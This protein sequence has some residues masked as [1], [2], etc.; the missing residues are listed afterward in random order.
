M[1]IV[2]TLKKFGVIQEMND[3]YDHFI[4]GT[5]G[6]PKTDEKI[7]EYVNDLIL[8]AYRGNV[9]ETNKCKLAPWIIKQ[10]SDIGYEN[11]TGD[12]NIKF[13]KILKWFI[14]SNEDDYSKIENSNIEQALEIIKKEESEKTSSVSDENAPH[15]EAEKQGRIK[16]LYNV[17]DGSKRIWVEV[18][19]GSWLSEP[20]ELN[21]YNKWGVMC[22]VGSGFA[23]SENQNIQ[24]IGPP[25]GH[26]NGL[27]STQAGMSGYRSQNSLREI[28]QEGNHQPGSQRTSAGYSDADQRIIDFLCF[29]D[30][31]KKNI[32]KI[33]TYDGNLPMGERNSSGAARFLIEIIN[34]KPDLLNKL[35]DHREDLIEVHKD[36]IV[37]IK[38]QQWLDE[39]KIDINTLAETD[40]EKFLDRFEDLI[41]RFGEPPVVQ[42]LTKIDIDKIYQKNPNLIL[43]N[44]SSFIGRIPDVEFEKIFNKIN[45][46]NFMKTYKDSFKD[47]LRF[48]SDQRSNKV[49]QGILI[50]ILENK[51]K[52][53]LEVFG[54]SALGVSNFLKFAESP[55]ERK[56]QNAKFDPLRK[57][58]KSVRYELI[59]NEQGEV[60]R[61]EEGNRLTKPVP[62]VIKDDK[63]VLIQKERKKFLEKNKELIK[64]FSK[65]TEFDKELMFMK[66]YAPQ[67]NDQEINKIFNSP[68]ADNQ[69]TFKDKIIDY[70]T[71]KY[72]EFESDKN[73]GKA[74]LIQKYGKNIFDVD[75]NVILKEYQP[76]ILEFYENF[77]FDNNKENLIPLNELKKYQSQIMTY[78]YHNSK[79]T[80][81][82]IK[83]I[84]AFAKFLNLC[85]KNKVSKEELIKFVNSVNIDLK[86]DIQFAKS[87]YAAVLKSLDKKTAISEL[88]KLKEAFYSFGE[89]GIRYYE[90]ISNSI[91]INK[92]EVKRGD[93][94]AFKQNGPNL[95]KLNLISGKLYRVIDTK[96]KYILSLEELDD[97]QEAYLSYE[98]VLAYNYYV[99]VAEESQVENAG[100]QIW[101]P[102]DRFKIK[103]TKTLNLDINENFKIFENQFS[104]LKRIIN[105]QSNNYVRYSAIVLDSNSK[106]KLNEIIE[107]LILENKIGENW[108]ISADHVT[109]N[110]G[111]IY[112]PT[113][114]GKE[115]DLKVVGIGLNDKVVALR[116][117]GDVYINYSTQKPRTPH[118]TLA[119]NIE[120]GAKPVMSNNIE[121]WENFENISLKGTIEEVY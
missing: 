98:N 79:E 55:R 100:Q 18:I 11:L 111:S 32:K 1:K 68:S 112:D 102:S 31:A 91:A 38:G 89:N 10:V 25:N 62:F 39:R 17:N 85:K 63:K 16:R 81:D 120:Q 117:T 84:D 58:Y 59:T 70:Y 72:K 109:I 29:S 104:K 105:E 88:N 75:G 33:T 78:Y 26:P 43:K 73:K 60:L 24:L 6:A 107:K 118:I 99:L 53:T 69:K 97:N 2:S 46:D 108:K 65:G 61:D 23:G 36:L 52:E 49:Y 94:I 48:L 56:H 74:F 66:F 22:Q 40:P 90:S 93:M 47:L 110:M 41:K 103:L 50:Y 57:V 115:V 121:N 86:K 8:S 119:Y 77:K 54:P 95:P 7:L 9:R 20:G 27:W 30:Y 82:K 116:V 42:E 83:R 51:T 45:I 3:W 64:N 114:L 35:A 13:E 37:S 113:L 21:E 34:G 87:F 4:D 101:V 44:I 19:D 15:L 5:G 67:L 80:D 92:Y 76:G 28:K 106:K 96:N 71:D 12:Y 14:K